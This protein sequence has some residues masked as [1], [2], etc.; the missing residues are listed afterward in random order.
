MKKSTEDSDVTRLESLFHEARQLPKG[1]RTSFLE[2]ACEDPE[3][4]E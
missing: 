4:R 1:E 3:L 2:N